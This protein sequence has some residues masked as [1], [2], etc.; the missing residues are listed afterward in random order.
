MDIRKPINKRILF[1]I[2]G[3]ILSILLTSVRSEKVLVVEDI[4]NPKKTSLVLQDESFSLGYIHSVLLTPASEYFTVGEDN[5]LDLYKT[6][7]ESFGVGLPFS[8]EDG[9]FEIVGDKFILKVE[10]SFDTLDMRIS[11]IPQHWIEISGERYE[12]ME[13]IEKPEDLI[14]LYAEDKWVLSVWGRSYIIF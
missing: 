14:K 6:E 8:K 13:L 10:R 9:E 4:D 11:S 2:A 3:L 7:Y 5:S 12:M 1:F